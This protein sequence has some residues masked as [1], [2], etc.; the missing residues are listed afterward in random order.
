MIPKKIHYC[1]FGSGEK[2]K[3]A[4]KCIESWKTFCP[5]YKIIEWNEDNFDVNMNAYTKMCYEQK[6]YAFLSDYVRLVAVFENG[7]I[8]FDTDVEAVKP[9]DELLPNKAFF[10]F[11]TK[12]YVNTGHGFGAEAKA[13]IV[14]ALIEAY[15]RVIDGQHGTVGCPVLNTEALVKNGFEMNGE[16]QTRNGV[17]V[18]AKE[19]F[20]PF[21]DNTGVLT[22]TDNTYSIH[23]YGKTWMDRKDIVRNK[24]TRV[25]HRMGLGNK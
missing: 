7:G 13:E 5:D 4:K 1:W 18:Y 2:P 12:D 6:N 11:E 22:K 20:N 16:T 17:V 9:F 15:D 3:L 21:N 25:I 23:W 24:L 10:G 14:K 8:Y 19:Y